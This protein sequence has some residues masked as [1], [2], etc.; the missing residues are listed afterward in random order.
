MPKAQ[1]TSGAGQG[2]FRQAQAWLHT[3]CGLWFSWL[4]F[5]VFLTGTLAVFAEPITHWMTPEHHAEEAAAQAA[6]GSA[7]APMAQ[8][9]RWASDYMQQHHPGAGMWELWPAD[10]Q[11]AGELRVYW[12]D[13]RRQYASAQ[14]DAASGM[15][16]AGS[17]TAPQRQTLGGQHFVDFHYQLHAGPIGLW[18]VGIA[19]LAML[20]ALVSGVITHRRIFQDFFT[21]RTGRGQRSWL[22]AH[23]AA[24]VLTLPFQFMIAYTGIVISGA[25]FLPAAVAPQFGAGDAGRIAFQAALEAPGKP[26][27]SGRAMAVPDLEPFVLRGQ[28]LMGQPVR[29]VVI[30]HPGDAAARIGIYG[31]NEGEAAQRRLSPT[32]GMALFSAASGELLQ[33]RQPGGVDGGKAALAQSVLGGLHMVKFGGFALKWLYFLCGLAG[34][35]MMATGAILFIVKRRTRHLGEF[36][37]ATVRVYRL[38]EAANVAAI[39]GLGL[40]CI[41]YLWANRLVPLGLAHRDDWELAVFFGVWALALVHALARAPAAAWKEQLGLLGA[42]CL[43]LP[44]LNA[45]TVGDHLPAQL[46]RGDWESAGVESFAL[47]TGLAALWARRV[48]ARRK[49]SAKPARRVARAADA[50]VRS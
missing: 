16:L 9:L 44:L 30:D 31:W 4:L 38:I 2:G 39:A 10:A 7:S 24:A 34:S 41:G 42:L 15:P 8:R 33:L 35:A 46:L 20:A 11:G 40:G 21:F 47:A 37:A 45:V 14:L 22:D 13:S 50:E 26:E 12:F 49:A 36:G 3:W 5:A 32:S 23:N 48:V 18:I 17:E 29:A 28:Q 27:P 25:T 19:A 1:T 6:S 43:L